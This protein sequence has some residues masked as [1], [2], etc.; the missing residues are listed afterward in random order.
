MGSRLSP[1]SGDARPIE[2]W[3]M[4]Q[5]PVRLIS[6]R[7]PTTVR[8][9]RQAQQRSGCCCLLMVV[10]AV[11]VV[12]VAFREPVGKWF[13]RSGEKG[14]LAQPAVAFPL[15]LETAQP[16]YYRY[17][18]IELRATLV[19]AQGR[20]AP[21]E[22]DPLV[23][24]T[25]DGEPVEAIGRV[26]KVRLKY[27][28]D[29]QIYVTYWPIPW[30]A[31]PGEYVAEARI[32]MKEPGKWAW[33]TPEERKK[34]RDE[35][36]P[37]VEGAGFC[38][39]RARFEIV[40]REKP[41]FAPGTCVATWEP[42]F[43]ADGIPKPTGGTGDWKTM[44]DWCEFVGADTFWF[45]GAVTE[46]YHGKLTFEQPFKLANIEAIPKL[47]A[48]AHRRGIK[49]GA[50]AVAYSTYPKK[51]K[52]KPPYD[53]ALDVSRSTG[54]TSE[55][56]F[57][58]L[59]DERR[60]DHLAEFVTLMEQ[61]ENVDYIGF[62]YFRSDRGG[63]EMV[64]KFTEEMPCRLPE[65]W[66]SYSLNRKRR[67]VALKVEEQWQTHPDFY[68]CW[69][70]WRA[71]LGGEIL[72]RIAQKAKPT[73]PLWIFVLSWRH[74]VQHGQDPLMLTDAGVTLL[75]PM[76]YQVPGRGH[77][78]TMT[79]EWN[80]YLRPD[81]VNIAV[82][83]QVDFYWHQKMIRP[84]AAPEE[85]YDRTVTA[86]R[87]YQPGAGVCGGAFW[88]D[89]SRAALWGDRGPYPGTEWALA[90]AAA[91]TTIR[92]D[93][94]VYP[95]RVTLK[96]LTRTGI[97]FTANVA[98]E[99]LCDKEIR[100]LAL[101]LMDTPKIESIGGKVKRIRS[102]GPKQ[103]IIVPVEGRISGASAARGNRFMVALRVTWPYGEYG[104]EFRNELPRQQTVIKYIQ[105]GSGG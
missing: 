26:P 85:L 34:V 73:K 1:V 36:P 88:H 104:K 47:A 29:K 100:D 96:D 3:A 89:I 31:P 78:D 91:F 46:V 82:G 92:S 33:R 76:L 19:D 61:E 40:A 72:A 90:G 57:I 48:E 17:A 37:K 60:I 15:Q 8:R 5:E 45:R 64:E 81:Q 44:L 105:L 80:S 65:A 25:R 43:R 102:L 63:Y 10:V 103:T 39:A 56:E 38:V 13:S 16:R 53:Y 28:R 41:A 83:D 71:H 98:I 67:H 54:A 75:A 95:L 49:F 86:H 66:D 94:N 20:P 51:N 23:A 59:L 93:C 55:R 4:R 18:L 9:R 79:K 97:G 42:D 11:I 30:N 68:D 101:R 69:N 2:I 50:W 27:D 70:W 14:Q 35:E 87:D 52:N 24:V 74:G 32:E 21:A 84:I 7:S 12:L 99:S 62:D 6:D 58:S 77:F 22:E